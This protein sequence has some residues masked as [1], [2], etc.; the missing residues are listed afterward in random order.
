MD[1]IYD[2]S[3]IDYPNLTT[4]RRLLIVFLLFASAIAAI[5]QWLRPGHKQ[6]GHE[7]ELK[8]EPLSSP[9]S[10]GFSSAFGAGPGL[11]C[12]T[13]SLPGAPKIR[14]QPG[15]TSVDLPGS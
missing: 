6:G 14:I 9:F 7:P 10:S 4:R 13:S 8:C 11:Q 5:G 3:A 12:E 2:P 15:S 1:D